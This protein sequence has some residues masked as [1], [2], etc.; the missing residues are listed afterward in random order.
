MVIRLIIS[1]MFLALTSFG[2]TAKSITLNKLDI[3]KIPTLE[4][5]LKTVSEEGDSV[6]SWNRKIFLVYLQEYQ[7]GL[8]CSISLI[9]GPDL[10]PGNYV[11][12]NYIGYLYIDKNPFFIL[13]RTKTRTK[14][15][16]NIGPI[17]ITNYR[18]RF[19]ADY[20]PVVDGVIYWKYFILNDEIHRLKFKSSW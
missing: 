7:G 11:G 13:N 2:I 3:S 20:I 6:C 14:T 17:I 16:T 19:P 8:N 15:R 9:E 1:F 12:S 18:R 4:K 5:V 10:P